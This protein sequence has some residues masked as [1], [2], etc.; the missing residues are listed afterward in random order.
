MLTILAEL[1]ISQPVLLALAVTLSVYLIDPRKHI[2]PNH[3][4]A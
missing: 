3:A 4:L 1:P 2:A